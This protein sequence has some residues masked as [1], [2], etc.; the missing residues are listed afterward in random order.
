MGAGQ[1]SY[2]TSSPFRILSFSRAYTIPR[3]DSKGMFMDDQAAPDGRE[4]I[5]SNVRWP[6]PSP[7]GDKMSMADFCI[8]RGPFYSTQRDPQSYHYLAFHNLSALCYGIALANRVFDCESV[9]HNHN[10]ARLVG[11]AVAAIEN[12]IR[13]GSIAQINKYQNT[14][15]HLRHGIYPDSGED[16]RDF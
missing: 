15:L 16:E 11:E 6:W 2:D 8:D 14:F 13:S 3:F 5:G 1:I 4:Y 9:D 12:I 10:I 7:I